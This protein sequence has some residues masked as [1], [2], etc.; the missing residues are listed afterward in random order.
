MHDYLQNREVLEMY[1]M[2]NVGL[3]NIQQSSCAFFAGD[4]AEFALLAES[5]NNT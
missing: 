3:N 1:T 2:V 4:W 5:Q